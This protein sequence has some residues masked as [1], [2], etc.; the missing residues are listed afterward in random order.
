[1]IPPQSTSTLVSPSSAVTPSSERQQPNRKLILFNFGQQVLSGNLPIYFGVHIHS[2]QHIYG[3][4]TIYSSGKTLAGI[5]HID[6]HEITILDLC[7][8]LSNQSVAEVNYLIAL[9]SPDVDLLGI[10][11]YESPVLVEVPPKN[12]RELPT[13]YRHLDYLGV[14]NQVAIAET[15]EGT[16]T[17]F[18]LDLN[19]LISLMIQSVE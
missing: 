3:K 7:R 12:I 15:E 11:L 2:I 13:S 14:A 17:A 6:D 4:T 16:Q 19:R 1:M 9:R 8:Y 10:P 5:A 18:L